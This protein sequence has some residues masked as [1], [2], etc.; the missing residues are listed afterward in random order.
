VCLLAVRYQE[1]AASMADVVAAE[2]AVQVAG[3]SAWSHL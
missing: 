3:C 1:L 2:P